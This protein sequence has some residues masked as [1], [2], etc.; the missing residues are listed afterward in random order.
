M[1]QQKFWQIQISKILRQWCQ[2]AVIFSPKISEHFSLSLG[3][4]LNSCRS[5]AIYPPSLDFLMSNCITYLTLNYLC[6]LWY[7]TSLDSC[8][9]EQCHPLHADFTLLIEFIIEFFYSCMPSVYLNKLWIDKRRR[10][11]LSP[12]ILHSNPQVFEKLNATIHQKGYINYCNETF[13]SNRKKNLYH[14]WLSS[15]K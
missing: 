10:P 15:H 13:T 7:N 4:P 9:K 5:Q 11:Y 6:K 2:H 14:I 12:C 8:S 3:L 1:S